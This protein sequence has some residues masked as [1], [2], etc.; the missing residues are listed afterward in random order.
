MESD[1]ALEPLRRVLLERGPVGDPTTVAAAVEAARSALAGG[2]DTPRL[3]EL[4]VLPEWD[5]LEARHLL[6]ELEQ[7]LWPALRLPVTAEARSLA[8]ARYCLRDLLDGRLE[9]LAAAE[10]IGYELWHPDDPESPLWPVRSWLH[11]AEDQLECCGGPSKELLT[12]LR[13][14]AVQLLAGPLA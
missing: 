9:P 13:A 6:S 3:W 4:G 1:E 8:L 2:M 10:R 14:L 7:E 12:E 11:R 5:A